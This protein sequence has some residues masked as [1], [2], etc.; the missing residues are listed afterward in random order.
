MQTGKATIVFTQNTLR[1]CS[2]VQKHYTSKQKSRGAH[3]IITLV[4]ESAKSST[5]HCVERHRVTFWEIGFLAK[6]QMRRL[7]V[8][9]HL[10]FKYEATTNS[11]SKA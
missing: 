8:P 11:L 5:Y 7:I 2:L 6:R 10:Y 1:V 3:A 4:S 9:S